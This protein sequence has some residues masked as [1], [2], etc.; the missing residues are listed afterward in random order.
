MIKVSSIYKRFGGEFLNKDGNNENRDVEFPG[1][2]RLGLELNGIFL[3]EKIL[4]AVCWG[5]QESEFLN[6]LS[7]ERKDIVLK[8]ILEK[9]PPLFILGKSFSYLNKLMALN[10]ELNMNKSA[11]IQTNLSTAEIYTLI[12]SWLS[13][14]MAKWNT[15]HG[16]V[17]NIWGEGVLLVGDPGVGKSETAVELI[18][19]NHLFLGDDAINIARVGN[20]VIAKPNKLTKEFIHLR[21]LGI[22]NIKEMFGIAKIIEETQISVVVKLKSMNL[23][24]PNNPEFEN[25]GD[26]STYYNIEGIDL[27]LYTLPVTSGRNM[28]D[29]VEMSVIDMKLKRQ[30]Y[31]AVNEIDKR[32]KQFVSKN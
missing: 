22:L 29:L 19:L 26:K 13:K 10:K 27:P 5:K 9:N 20:I 11:I 32:Y 2:T 3:N 25:L 18:K 28:P 1:F 23:D 24:D 15:I 6:T 14:S 7:E 31:N 12:G 8:R 30:G 4:S 16:T 17:L 21:G